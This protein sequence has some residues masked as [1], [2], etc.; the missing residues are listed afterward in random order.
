MGSFTIHNLLVILFVFPLFAYV[1]GEDSEGLK[2]DVRHIRITN[3]IDPGVDL[4]FECK[5]R[6]DDFGK[7]VL[8]YNT[9]WEFQFRPNFWGTTRYYCWFAWRNEFKWFDIYDHNRDASECRHC[10]WTIQP[11]GPCM[12]NKAENNYDICY[13]WN[14]PDRVRSAIP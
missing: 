10:V 4:T 1:I 5:S 3:K 8:H 9:Y 7:K 6:D 11:D 14:R 12:L 13:F 2:E